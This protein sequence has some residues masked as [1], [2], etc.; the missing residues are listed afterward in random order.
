MTLEIESIKKVESEDEEILV[1]KLINDFTFRARGTKYRID[2]KFGIPHLIRKSFIGIFEDYSN[3]ILVHPTYF[4]LVDVV[5]F[6]IFNDI[7]YILTEIPQHF[8][9]KIIEEDFLEDED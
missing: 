4:E 1:R 6:Q 8:K 9:V 7:R 3:K 2:V 5:G